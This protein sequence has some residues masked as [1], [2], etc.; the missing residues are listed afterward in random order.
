MIGA[1][2][3]KVLESGTSAVVGTVAA[4]GAPDASRSW[5][6][7]TLDGGRRIRF[8]LPERD[9]TALANLRSVGR[10]ALTATEVDTLESVQVKGQ[11]T[12]VGP[13][14]ADDLALHRR[15]VEEF[16]RNVHEADGTP[17]D[18]LRGMVPRGL[19]AVEAEVEGVWDQTPGPT[20]GRSL[21]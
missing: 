16:L 7:W 20:A 10:V 13:A 2:E 5:G 12:V 15:Y 3:A 21:A 4:D 18:L 9:A 11:A 1:D 8:L 17:I 14:T 6:C 19:V